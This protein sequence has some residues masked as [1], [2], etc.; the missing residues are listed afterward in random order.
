MRWSQNRAPRLS[1]L[2]ALLIPE[3]PS[4]Q[5]KSDPLGKIR[6]LQQKFF[7]LP[8]KADLSDTTNFEYLPPI[9][10]EPI[11]TLEVHQAIMRLTP[12]KAPGPTL[13]P[14]IVLQYL[15]PF[16]S[17]LLKRVF[18]T[19]LELGYC[20]KLCQDSVTV[21]MQKPYKNN[22]TLVKAYRP[23]LLLD[24]IGK[25]FESI[26][27]RRISAITEIH[28]LLPNTHFSGR[29]NT[30]TEHAVHF[31]IKKKYAAWDRGEEASALMLDI[32]G[33]FYN[34]S[35]L[36]LIH[37]LQKKRLDPQIISW[38]ASFTQNRSII[39]KTNECSSNLVHISTGIPQGSPLLP[40]LYLFYNAD[41]LEICT[42]SSSHTFARGF[43]DDTVL[44]ATSPN[45][46][47]NCELLKETHK[48]CANCAKKHASQFDSSK[49]QLVY[50]SRKQNMDTNKDLLLDN[51]FCIKAQKS[52]VLLGVEIDNQLKWKPHL[53]QIKM[54]ASKSTALSCLAGSTWGGKL[55]T[56]RLL[57]Q[58]IVI[59]QLTYCCSV[60][61]PPPNEPGHRKYVLKSLQSIQGRALKVV[62]GAFKATS[63]PALDIEA[64]VLPIQ[65]KLDKLSCESLL[66]I[67]SCQRYK[68]VV[69]QRPRTSKNKI[70]S[71]LEILCR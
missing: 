17:P 3:S 57:Y 11:T 23:I 10:T 19:N 62:T 20:A 36:R 65:Q 48:L 64:F 71:P 46:T 66:Q 28:H 30:S 42:S 53:E 1:T 68:T 63:L 33:A 8:P 55:K 7:P 39:I 2:P 29:R 18:N 40:I 25:T 67:A 34:V 32:T 59:P 44:L 60:W 35:Q 38:I 24:T 70:I 15:A 21:A 41:L 13:I 14:N 22:Y 54:R 50:L 61:Y 27:A 4:A 12:F 49:Y 31:L 26:L 45:T 51:G 37:N 6:L 56:I 52:G 47:E 9:S 5:Y 69:T 58:S 16:L 43:I